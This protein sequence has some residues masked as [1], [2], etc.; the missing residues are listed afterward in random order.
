MRSKT[1]RIADMAIFIALGVV[2]NLCSFQSFGTYL[3][4]ISLVYLFCYLSGFILGPWQGFAVAFIADIIPG[5]LLPQGPYSVLIGLSNAL[6]AMIAG[7]YNRYTN[8]RTVFKLLATAGTA[9]VVCTLGL[10]AL[11]ETTSVFVIP[12]GDYEAA[13]LYSLYP[14]TLAKVIIGQGWGVETP[15]LQMMLSKMI[16]Q[17]LWIVLN[18]IVTYV[19]YIRLIPVL[20]KAGY[21]RKKP[22]N[23]AEEPASVAADG[24]GTA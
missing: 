18:G 5:L 11:G 24:N 9:F 14:Y 2:L 1:Q 17:P 10:T 7:L 22:E 6:M 13:S 19:I 20:E 23:K 4:R 3:G 8:W 21:I 16:S 15:Y 12:I